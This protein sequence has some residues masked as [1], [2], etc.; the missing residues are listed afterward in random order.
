M[1][2]EIEELQNENVKL[3][4]YLAAAVAQIENQKQAVIDLEEDLKQQEDII[5]QKE[6]ENDKLTQ[7]LSDAKSNLEK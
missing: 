3:K 6:E 4:S 7:N 5:N 2:G 1:E